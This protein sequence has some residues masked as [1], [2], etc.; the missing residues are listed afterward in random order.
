M[1][2]LA[3]WKALADLA[4]HP[5]TSCKGRPYHA[6]CLP[7]SSSG[8]F[9]FWQSCH[10]PVTMWPTCACHV[11]N[12]SS[13][14]YHVT[15]MSSCDYHVTSMCPML[16]HLQ[17][18]TAHASCMHM[19]WQGRRRRHYEYSPTLRCHIVT[20]MNWL[21]ASTDA[22]LL[23]LHLYNSAHKL[24]G[25]LLIVFSL[26]CTRPTWA[27]YSMCTELSICITVEIEVIQIHNSVHME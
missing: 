22:W 2:S 27:C 26:H 9:L 17:A 16:L 21:P 11:T 24:Y 4:M 13:C 7:T 1:L 8:N 5:C 10:H 6:D 15:S 3:H 20:A 12:M 19:W 23:M 18:L 25:A 14:D